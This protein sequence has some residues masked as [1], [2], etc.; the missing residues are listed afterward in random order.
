MKK[1]QLFKLLRRHIKLSEKRSVAYEQNKTAKTVIYIMSGFVIIYILFISLALA[2]IANSADYYTPYEFLFG[3]APYLLVLDFAARFISQQTPVQLIKPYSLLPIPKYTCIELFLLS[4]VTS[5]NNLLWVCLTLP[6]VIMTT[7]FSEGIIPSA[8]VIVAFQLLVTINSQWYMLVR[9]LINKSMKWWILPLV[10]YAAIFS[11]MYFIDLDSVFNAWSSTGGGFS[12]FNP[13]HYTAIILVLWGFVEI[14]KRIQY[15]MT[16]LENAN[17]ENAKMGKVRELKIFNRYG[18]TGEY[19]KLEVKSLMRNKNTR[20]TFVFGTALIIIF[21]LIISLTD[22][23]DTS[24]Y[25]KFWVVYTFVLY[26][27]M[28]LIKIMSAEGNYIDGLM[29]HK[30]N[31][32]Q[33]LK[34]KYIFYSSILVFP[35][36]LMLPTVFTGKYTL[37]MLFSMA[38]FTAGPIYF[39]LMQMAVYNRQTIPLNTKFISKGNIENNYFQI[40]VELLAMFMP[41]AFISLLDSACGETSAYIIML[42]I[43]AAFILL[44]KLWIRNIY[45]RLMARRYKN[46]ESFRATR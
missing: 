9:T 10:V 4:S 17:T 41:I 27:C 5:P 38:V 32:M 46:M 25:K 44:H 31:I 36:L 26:G 28:M 34:A 12:F 22:I 21:S 19:L 13:L 8:G 29:I 6:Y 20:K 23:Y 45:K 18:E 39:L 40:V 33:L 35:F 14:N 1:L 16:Y 15:R 37:L 30:E 3:M 43:G 7:L 24:F 42:V 2:L 11:P